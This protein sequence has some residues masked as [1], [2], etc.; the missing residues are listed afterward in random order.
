ML[1]NYELELTVLTGEVPMVGKNCLAG[2][3]G[4]RIGS[5]QGTE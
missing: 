1:E 3:T 4:T 2:A 5:R